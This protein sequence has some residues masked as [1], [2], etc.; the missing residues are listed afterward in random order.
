[1]TVNVATPH[2]VKFRK[3]SEQNHIETPPFMFS[4][5]RGGGVYFFG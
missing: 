4:N 1:M 5:K 3:N 2:Y